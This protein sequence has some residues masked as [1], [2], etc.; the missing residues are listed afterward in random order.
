VKNLALILIPIVALFFAP[1]A[2]SANN[3]SYSLFYSNEDATNVSKV[4]TT[5]S[6]VTNTQE[7]LLSL[8]FYKL[9]EKPNVANLHPAV[10]NN[11]QLKDIT[12]DQNGTLYLDFNDE[13]MNIGSRSAELVFIKAVNYT[14]F[15]NF[16]KISHIY[17]T[18]NGKTLT[19]LSHIDV[20]EGFARDSMK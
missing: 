7:Q 3:Q 5:I 6:E 1:L 10:P 2:L 14:Y 9:K 12:L 13:V 17:Y 11:I 15:T 8:L 19:S 4:E 20:S 16:P 18:V